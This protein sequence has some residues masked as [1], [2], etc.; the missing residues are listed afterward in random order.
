[1]NGEQEEK[2]M[3]ES[4]N[5]S[6]KDRPENGGQ[7][8]KR[9]MALTIG[10]AI[11][12]VLGIAAI[13][14]ALTAGA[15]AA[16][17]G[18]D[19]DLVGRIWYWTEFSGPDGQ[20]AV[21]DPS[22]Y[23]AEFTSDGTVHIRADCNQANSTYTAS[24]GNLSIGLM[25]MTMAMCE[26]DSLSDN[27]VAALSGAETYRVEDG[28]LTIE[29]QAGGGTMTF[30]DTLPEQEGV[31]VDPALIGKVW[32]WYEFASPTDTIVVDDP[33]LYTVEFMAE[34]MVQVRADCNQGSGSYSASDGSISFGPMAVTLAMCEPGSFSDD[35]LRALDGVA[36][37]SFDGD[38]LLLDLPADSGTLKLAEDPPEREPQVDPELVGKVWKWY[39]FVDPVGETVVEDPDS[40]TVEFTAEGTVHIRAD[41]N[42]SNGTVT[43]DGGQ[44]DIEALAMTRAM[45]PPGSL[46]DDFVTALNA[47]ALYSFDGNTLLL[48]LPMDSGTLKLAENPPAP[49]AP[50][51]TP[52]PEPEVDPDLLGKVWQW[53][54]FVG[55]EQKVMPDDPA[56]YTVE[57]KADGTIQVRADCNQASGRYTARRGQMSIGVMAMTL[58]ACPPGS[59]SDAFVQGLE[60]ATIYSFDGNTLLLDLPMDGGTMMLAENPP[61]PPGVDPDLAGKTWRW[62]EFQDPTG[63]TA[64]GEPNRYLLL[65]GRDGTVRVQADCNAASGGYTAGGGSLSVQIGPMTLA[66]CP[67]GSL[68]DQFLANLDAAAVYTVQGGTL[69]ID[70]VADGG[71]M[72]FDLGQ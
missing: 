1:M 13:V 55:A 48:D 4:Y 56:S 10:V 17:P 69:R 22:R 53:Y 54:Q 44:I 45:C 6:A 32:Q 52:T 2:Q 11:A 70:L 24:D 25:A 30:S 5:G 71:T 20:I 59:L 40:Y 49:P 19:R 65:F 67:P 33:N 9:S 60:M 36:V 34:G 37:Y 12:G 18:V 43:A 14:L 7:A 31:Q 29:L 38:T 61:V 72:T 47:A 15:R 23:T 35:F 3:S 68:S 41:C 51:P 42:R 27:F 28:A 58:A 8:D 39:E 21:D 62:I 64:V 66:A 46:S 50:Q 16:V 26:P 63:T 57:F